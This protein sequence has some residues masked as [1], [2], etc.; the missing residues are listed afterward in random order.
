MIWMDGGADSKTALPTCGLPETNNSRDTTH[1]FIQRPE[2]AVLGPDRSNTDFLNLP[3]P[4]TLSVNACCSPKRRSPQSQAKMGM[5]KS[6]RIII[7]LVVDTA[8][9]FLELIV[10]KIR[11]A[12]ILGNR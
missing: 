9:F 5:S 1:H 3:S 4:S 7:L 2:Q 11:P 6:S 10:G 8:F 12:R